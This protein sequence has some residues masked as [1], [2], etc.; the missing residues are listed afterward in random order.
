[1]PDL[2]YKVTEENVDSEK[3]ESEL[4][5]PAKQTGPIICLDDEDSHRGNPM[6]VPSP[7]DYQ[8]E[9]LHDGLS[10]EPNPFMVEDMCHQS[11]DKQSH[12][13]MEVEPDRY[14]VENPAMSLEQLIEPLNHRERD[15]IS[16]MQGS[17]Y[18]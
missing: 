10:F 14:Q 7:L 13:Q 6:P 11:I 12:M 3:E 18:L 4:E 1:M 5:R 17:R 15:Y 16:G 8:H 9:N 2:T